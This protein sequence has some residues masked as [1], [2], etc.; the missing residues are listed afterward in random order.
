MEINHT[1]KRVA[2]RMVPVQP[3]C[4][5]FGGFELQMINAMAAVRDIGIDASP[6][7]PWSQTNNFNITHFWGFEISHFQTAKWAYLSDKKLIM[8]MLLSNYSHVNYLRNFFSRLTGSSRLKFQMLNWL[9][10]IAV[11]NSQQKKYAHLILNIPQDKIHIIPNIV[12]DIFFDPPSNAHDF[13]ID[14][15]NYILC[16]GNICK[17]KNQLLLVRACRKLGLP[18][19]IVGSS[20]IGEDDYAKAL[21]D[22]MSGVKNMIWI[23]NLKPGS[24][25]LASAYKN[26]IAFA[27]PSH[28][29]TQ[30]ISA[31]EA[32][33]AGKP[34]LLGD[35]P[36]AQQEY[37][38]NGRLVS[39]TSID[40]IT[41]GLKKIID[42]PSNHLVPKEIIEKCR[43]AN[44]G[45]SYKNL[46]E[47][48]LQ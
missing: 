39:P 33:A 15:K 36:Y 22:E 43:R 9:S 20:M 45:N 18:L 27:L 46:Y 6:L 17:R 21:K 23:Q 5:A 44:I 38:T 2:V 7:D 30:P 37:F 12:E 25:A 13:E 16:T 48:V 35:L 28:N 42:S 10:A 4:F 24:E 1:P 29:E 26:C 32:A 14:I 31:L 19:L 3:H 40:A 8:T 41:N 11:V 34:L 47:Q